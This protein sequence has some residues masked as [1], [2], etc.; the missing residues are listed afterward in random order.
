MPYL[1]YLYQYSPL[2]IAQVALVIW[3]LVDANRRGVEYYWFWI[4]LVFQPLGAWVY[5]FAVKAGDFRGHSA[6]PNWNW[7]YRRPSL[8][9]LRAY[10]RQR[11]RL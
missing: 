10:R 1:P 2:Y 7:F 8:D 6:G 5:F 4:I 3:M 11:R 9:E